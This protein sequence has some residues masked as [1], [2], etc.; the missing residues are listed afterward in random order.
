MIAI[1]VDSGSLR[2]GYG[3]VR[4]AGNR[5]R[6]LAYGVIRLQPSAPHPE[7]LA[8]IHRGLKDLIRE[9][10][11]DVLAL[12]GAFF[13]VNAQSALKLGQVRGAVMVTAFMEGLEV[14]EYSPAEVK[15]AVTG[16]GR[17]AKEQ[18]QR[19]VKALLGLEAI[20]EPHDAADALAL[21]LCAIA[22]SGWDAKVGPR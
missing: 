5:S 1:G 16:H 13:S 15:A 10:R 14:R 9:H 18:V 8:A 2:T 12:E 21:A 4:G 7:R 20:P 11:P 22:R 17:A 3:V 6:C 19:M